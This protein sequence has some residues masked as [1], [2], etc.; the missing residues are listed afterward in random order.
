MGLVNL[1]KFA[2][3]RPVTI[4]MCL[5]TIVYFG[6]QSVLGAKVELTPEM[7]LPMLLISTVYAGA[8]PEDI[9]ELIISKEED[10]ISTLSG[11]DTVQAVSM[12]NVAIVMIQYEYGTNM[13]TAYIDLKKAIDAVTD[14]PDDAEEPTIMELDINSMPVITLAVSGD[15]DENLYTY[16][17]NHIVP[18]FEK[19]SSV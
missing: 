10:A 4:I 16:V 1:S 5:I 13:D 3:K 2:L 12:E 8:S 19:L 14:L 7:E 15:T 17:E 18:E 9:N 6:F 11:V